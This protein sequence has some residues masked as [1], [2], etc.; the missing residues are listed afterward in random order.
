MNNVNKDVNMEQVLSMSSKQHMDEES[1]VKSVVVAVFV[2]KHEASMERVLTSK[3]NMDEGSRVK[4][5]VVFDAVAVV[6]VVFVVVAVVAVVVAAVSC[7]RQ[8][9]AT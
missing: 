5:V 6:V 7:L 9:V 8:S 3:Q 2:F 4:S 1:H